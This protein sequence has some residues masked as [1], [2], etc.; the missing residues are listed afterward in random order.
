MV[1]A[2][3]ILLQAEISTTEL[4]RADMFLPEF[5][6]GTEKLY[7]RSSMTYNVHISLHLV[8]SVLN[9]GPSFEH[10]EFGFESE[11]CELLKIIHAA[12]YVHQQVSRH[13]HL[14]SSYNILQKRIFPQASSDV[15]K[16]CTQLGPS[17]AKHT[18]GLLNSRYFGA[19]R[20]VQ[21]TW[22]GKLLF[23]NRTRSYNKMVKDG[24][25]Y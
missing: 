25:L 8:K 17:H 3:Y 24:C 1:E 20:N 10:S 7:S 22:N 23:S 12:K 9:W 19:P 11:N 21:P 18:V 6:V 15:K 13:I 4:D 2:L 5:V 16:F 14:H